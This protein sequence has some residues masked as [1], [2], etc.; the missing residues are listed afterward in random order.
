MAA[1]RAIG[2]VQP[3]QPTTD[4][5]KQIDVLSG[6]YCG[7]HGALEY[8]DMEIQHITA[9]HRGGGDDASL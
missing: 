1:N 8:A 7:V 3:S 2:G 9:R 5:S 4:S 6:S